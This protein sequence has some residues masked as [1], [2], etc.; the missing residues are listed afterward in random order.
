MTTRFLIGTSGWNYAHWRRRFYPQHLPSASWLAYYAGHF[1]TVEV[2]YTFYRLPD[3]AVF[4][5]WRRAVPASFVFAVKASRYITHIKRLRTARRSVRR[6]LTRARPLGRTLSPMLF[7]LPPTLRCDP[8]R[9]RRFL[10]GLPPGRRYA[11]EFRHESWHVPEVYAI[12]RRR[13]VACCISDSRDRP[14][15]VV[16]TA[17]FVYVRF[18]GTG[19]TG[20]YGEVALRRWADGLRTVSEDAHTTYVYF[21]NDWQGY[22]VENAARLA[23]LLS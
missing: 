9:L 23:E 10:T 3:G 5:S 21:N 1:H 13:R 12:L 22:A 20:R 17:P 19:V 2:N 7:Q 8:A 4:R 14:V 16:R 15:H 11:V 6:L 18:H